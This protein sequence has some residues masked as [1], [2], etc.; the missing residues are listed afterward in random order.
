MPITTGVRPIADS[1]GGILMPNPT[2]WDDRERGRSRPAPDAGTKPARPLHSAPRLTP[3][4]LKIIEGEVIPRLLLAHRP[5]CG[6]KGLN[7]VTQAAQKS[8]DV[9]EFVRLLLGR[10]AAVA[11]GYVEAMR[12]RGLS[13]EQVYLDLLAPAARLLGEM[14]DED[15]RSF[16]DVTSALFR[17]RQLLHE[18]S[19]AFVNEAECADNGQ[20]VLLM[21]LPGELHTFGLIMVG[22]FF[23][24]AGWDVWDMYPGSTAELRTLARSQWFSVIGLSVSCQ[25]RVAELAA[26]IRSVREA[27]RNPQV[28]VMIG[29]QPFIDRADLVAAVGADG[30]GSD[31]R[32]AAIEATK[33]LAP[34]ENRV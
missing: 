34:R 17:M 10:D 7:G 12:A 28:R 6:G 11:V 14:W 33:L 26:I 16:A 24:R 15:L 31:G 23:R 32:H 25:T 8:D 22:E 18:F 29:G 5:A 13:L 1:R 30:S 27:S 20:R 4:L 9:N 21:P 19:P 3:R 2:P